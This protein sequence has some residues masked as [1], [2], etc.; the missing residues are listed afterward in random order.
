MQETHVLLPIRDGSIELADSG[1]HVGHG[2]DAHT[3]THTRRHLAG[4]EWETRARVCGARNRN[5]NGT[6][7]NG[8]KNVE[9]LTDTHTHTQHLTQMVGALCFS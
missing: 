7:Q 3:L 2:C 9:V 4:A 6:K 8:H 1:V 5:R